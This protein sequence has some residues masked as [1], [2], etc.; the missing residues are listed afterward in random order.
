M[1]RMGWG[2][3]ELQYMIGLLLNRRQLLPTEF[4][5]QCIAI[6]N[7]YSSDAS[8]LVD[9]IS[10]KM[11]ENANTKFYFESLKNNSGFEVL[12]N[13]WCERL[14]EDLRG[15]G[16]KTGVEGLADQ[17]Y[18]ERWKFSS[19]PILRFGNWQ[20][21]GS[22]N[23]QLEVPMSILVLDGCA[24]TAKEKESDS[25]D[26]MGLFPYDY[27]LGDASDG[28]K[29]DVKKHLI[30]RPYGRAFDEL[31][32]PF[33]FRRGIYQNW[34]LI[35]DIEHKQDELL[36]QIIPYWL[37]LKKG[38]S[39]TKAMPEQNLE[40]TVAK[41]QEAIENM[42]SS[43]ET[44]VH[45]SS[46]DSELEHLIPN[47][48]N[49]F[50]QELFSHS[51]KAIISGFGLVDIPSSVTESRKES[52]VN[53]QGF[54]SELMK[55]QTDFKSIMKD[56][57]A[58]IKAQNSNKQK[59]GAEK[60][61]PQMLPPREYLTKEVK[62]DL[63]KAH[64]RG[65]ISNRTYN[66]LVV[67][68]WMDAPIEIEIKR[69]KFEAAEGTEEDLYARVI[70]NTEQNLGFDIPT[71]PAEN[72]DVSD[73]KK[74][75]VNTKEKYNIASKMQLESAPYTEENYPKRLD[76]YPASARDAWIKAFNNAL[77]YY[78]NESIAF[79]LAW[80]VLRLKLKDLNRSGEISQKQKKKMYMASRIHQMQIGSID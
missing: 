41:L 35:Y 72:E 12:L 73:D 10:D 18:K 34:K 25:K 63:H 30:T 4:R 80:K 79:R 77:E 15:Y 5:T 48:E 47:M 44:P 32:I 55:A 8:G 36:S 7:I 78:K 75:G 64:G 26:L 2:A 14:N 23:N 62:E 56:F 46:S 37:L 51:E 52:V 58:I 3:A 21:I 28:Y 60:I 54:M 31:P 74:D 57:I 53:P 76:D 22:G 6:K 40:K 45:A 49:M 33:M 50:K 67:S 65:N 69:R 16:I 38:L 17:Y 66:E 42:R 13:E 19:F 68:P 71:K 11:V 27:F 61:V 24:I 70:Q 59:Y 1:D 29:I 39:Q 9:S 20:K 43:G